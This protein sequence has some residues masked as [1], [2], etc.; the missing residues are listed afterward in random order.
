MKILTRNVVLV[1]A[2]LVLAAC[3]GGSSNSNAGDTLT[4]AMPTD[5]TTFDT[6]ESGGTSS[7]AVKNMIYEGLTE[8]QQNSNSIKAMPALATDWQVNDKDWTFHLRKDVKFQD[9]TPFNADAVKAHFT[10]LLGPEKPVGARDFTPFIKSVDVVDDHTVVFHSVFPDPELPLRLAGPTGQIES[11][12]AFAK[13][14]VKDYKLHPVGTGPFKFSEWVQDERVELTRYDDFWGGRPKLAKVVMRPITEA[15]ARVI[16]VKS[17]DVQLA[18]SVQPEQLSELQADS[19]LTVDRW[20]TTRQIFIGMHNLKKPFDDVRVRQ[21]M[22]YAI[23]WDGIAKNIYQ[24]M[25]K[26]TGGPVPPPELGAAQ[27]SPFTY[28]PDKARQLLA[29][30]GYAKGFS[31]SITATVGAYLKDTEFVQA[32]QQQLAAVGIKLQISQAEFSRYI[33]LV[34]QPTKTSELVVWI[35]SW[36]SNAAADVLHDRYYCASYRPDGVNITG[37]CNHDV[38]KLIDQAEG[39]LNESTRDATLQQAQ[40]QVGK[41]APSLWGVYIDTADVAQKNVRGLVRAQDEAVW[42]DQSTSIG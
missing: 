22:S 30:A 14:G 31:S 23:D 38:D 25:A 34:R 37:Y 32:V 20:P 41:D 4:Y 33:D 11:P 7:N 35:D 5:V 12:A 1:L 24:G 42:A 17:G 8:L 13:Y 29:E 3:E 21:A 27:V 28:D 26:P 15:G 10:R 18:T 39:D 36:A 9:G 6:V 40:E 16:A 19:N 2:A